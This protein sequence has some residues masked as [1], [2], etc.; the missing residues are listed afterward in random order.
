MSRRGGT[1]L[2]PSPALPGRKRLKIERSRKKLI[3]EK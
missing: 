3:Q 1:A 2:A